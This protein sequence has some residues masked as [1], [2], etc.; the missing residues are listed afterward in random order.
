MTANE[1]YDS[2]IEKFRRFFENSLFNRDKKY[3][4][5]SLFNLQQSMEFL[6]KALLIKSS[7]DFP[8][9]HNLKVLLEFLSKISNEKCKNLINLYISKNGIKLS[10]LSDAYISS[11]YFVSSYSLNDVDELIEMIK[12]FRE[13]IIN[14]C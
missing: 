12:N 9:S 3:Y 5:I 14:V 1:K 8:K 6:L 7:G 4:D 11:G 2:Y 13:E 10:Y